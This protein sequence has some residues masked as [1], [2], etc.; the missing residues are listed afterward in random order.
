MNGSCSLQNHKQSSY[1]TKYQQT[2]RSLVTRLQL[3]LYLL[4]LLYFS[5]VFVFKWCDLSS[6]QPTQ[7]SFVSNITKR[8]T[9]KNCL[10]LFI[11]HLP[12]NSSIQIYIWFFC[13]IS[14]LFLTVWSDLRLQKSW[15][16]QTVY[17]VLQTFSQKNCI[18]YSVTFT[19]DHNTLNTK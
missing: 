9:K 19:T 10:I 2:A 3:R 13:F 8:M 4:F 5:G 17:P 14:Q 6:L 18:P 16:R 11:I 7:S 12:I 1:V 15:N